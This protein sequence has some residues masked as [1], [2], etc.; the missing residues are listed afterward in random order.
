[1]SFLR[2]KIKNIKYFFQRL[3]RALAEK[4]FFTF[5][6]LFLIALIMAGLVFYK[7][8]IL[9]KKTEL[10]ASDQ[11]IVFPEETRRSVLKF[12]EEREEK[13]DAADSRNY[14]N[15]FK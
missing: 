5:L 10:K 15:P 12:W 9:A 11:Q 13:F 14:L 3:P 6:C 7:Y 8:S 2:P 4:A 1:M